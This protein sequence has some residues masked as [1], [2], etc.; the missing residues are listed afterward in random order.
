MKKQRT[1][2]EKQRL[3]ETWVRTPIYADNGVYNIGTRYEVLSNFVEM[4]LIPFVKRK[5]YKFFE[6]E[7]R[8]TICFLHYLFALWCGETVKFYNPH[9]ELYNDHWLE[10][11]HRFD[12][13]ELEALWER[14][15][16]IQDFMPDR[17]AYCVQYTLPSFLWANLDIENSPITLKIEQIM[18]EV[19]EM[20]E[21]QYRLE[22]K[23]KDDP[24][25]HESSRYEDKHW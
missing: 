5:G 19:V 10:F 17:Y 18:E 16:C 7:N 6:N 4:G 25:L 8:V 21:A 22:S 12:S 23:G 2:L 13:V 9:K 14:W 15:G 24:Y 20:E 11:E 1:P 3:W